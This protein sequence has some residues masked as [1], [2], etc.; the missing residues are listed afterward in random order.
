M[1]GFD[2]YFDPSTYTSVNTDT[3]PSLPFWY[4]D[5]TGKTVI[6]KD[7]A[8]VTFNSEFSPFP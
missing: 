4:I 1:E 2:N 5:S 3:A 8:M 6:E 7:K